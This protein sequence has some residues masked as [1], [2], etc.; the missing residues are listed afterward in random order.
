M[1]A[2]KP[3]GPHAK[4]SANTPPNKRL[5]PANPQPA[6]AATT[7]KHRQE[8]AS[9]HNALLTWVGY[10]ALQIKRL[11]VNA[12]QNAVLVELSHR[13]QP[14]VFSS[15][16]SE[17]TLLL[18]RFYSHGTRNRF[19]ISSTHI[20]PHSYIRA[21]NSPRSDLATRGLDKKEAL[22]PS[23]S[24]STV[25]ASARSCPSRSTI[26]ARSPG[27]RGRIGNRWEDGLQADIEG[28][29]SFLFYL[30]RRGGD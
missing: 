4:P 14:G 11:P 5:A 16:S 28:V 12:R 7:T 1:A 29:S 30:S 26:P 23:S 18:E 27:T 13:S 25:P 19:T 2:K 8:F 6:P 3:T 20:V 9:A 15:V 10:Q 21:A 17:F 22:T 24:P